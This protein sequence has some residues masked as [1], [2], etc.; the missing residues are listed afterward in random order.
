MSANLAGNRTMTS[1]LF[2]ALLCLNVP[3]SFA[4]TCKFKLISKVI[5]IVLIKIGHFQFS[6]FG[7]FAQMLRSTGFLKPVSYSETLFK[8]LLKRKRR[9]LNKLI[10]KSKAGY[11]II[12]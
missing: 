7:T 2:V 12:N 10:S 9:K 1:I 8:I 3:I 6:L 11:G 5:Q 4:V